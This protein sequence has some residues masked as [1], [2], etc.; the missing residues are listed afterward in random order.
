MPIEPMPAPAGESRTAIITG[1]AGQDGYFLARRLLTEGWT[2]HAVVR[3][4]HG[5]DE[6]AKLS[7]ARE[8][9]TIHPVDVMKPAPL[10]ELVSRLQPDELY[11][12]AGRSSIAMSFRDPLHTWRTNVAFLANLLERVRLDSPATRFYQASSTDMFGFAPGGEI[13]HNEDSPFN[14]QSPY[15]AAKAAA[16]LLCKS[17]RQSYGLRIA[18]GIL[19]NHESRRRT[20]EFLSRKVVD[21]VRQLRGASAAQ[22]QR[23]GPLVMGNLKTRRDWGFAP[24]FVEGMCMVLR[25]IAVRA[26]IRNVSPEPDVG[27]NYRD[28][29]LGTGQA[30][31]VWELVDRAFSLGGMKL[32]WHLEGDDPATWGATFDSST[33]PAVVLDPALL[34]PADPTAICID[35]TRANDELGWAPRPGLDVFLTDMLEPLAIDP[36]P[37]N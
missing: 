24:D 13:R 28:Y 17:Y 12:L 14:P 37:A 11:N 30:H 10:L 9:L 31:A 20:P 26:R 15:A 32:N 23:I 33:T 6:L 36:H 16:H 27:A 18:S 22:R 4:P 29:L 25:Q 19:S 3:R 7:G 1:A 5:S 21:H 34:R 2:V 35:P 8:R